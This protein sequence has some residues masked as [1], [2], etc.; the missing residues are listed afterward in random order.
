MISRRSF[1]KTGAVAAVSGYVLGS[2]DNLL[3][4]MLQND[5]MIIPSESLSDPLLT[6]VS[7][8]FKPFVNTNFKLQSS[9]MDDY[10]TLRLIEVKDTKL[11]S[12][13]LKGYKGESFSLFFESNS[14][15]PIEGK[16]YDISHNGLGEFSL[17]IQ[18]VTSEPNLYEAIINRINF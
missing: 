6:F 14:K 2:T 16:T 5:G 1:I 7:E 15:M 18:P 12:N 13:M 9:E 17:F 10:Q 3:G 4:Q 8:H 11:K